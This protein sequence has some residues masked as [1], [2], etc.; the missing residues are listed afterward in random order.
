MIYP[1]EN[2]DL[3]EKEQ[4]KSCHVLRFL[5][6]CVSDDSFAEAHY[7]ISGSQF[8]VLAGSDTVV[9]NTNIQYSCF[10]L[11]INPLLLCCCI[12]MQMF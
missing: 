12:V 2:Y 4:Q 10:W 6:F 11:W 3:P 5:L 8:P 9:E 7:S 1:G